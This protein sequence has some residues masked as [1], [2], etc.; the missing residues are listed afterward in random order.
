MR[1][2]KLIGKTQKEI[3]SDADTI[4][5]QLMVRAGMIRQ[6]SAGVYSY[7][8]LAHRALKKV[9]NIIRDEMDKAG[10]QEV[11][12]PVLQPGE[13]WEKSG[14]GQAFGKILFQVKDRKDRELVLGP[15]HE[16]VI[17]D[18]VSFFVKSY[19]DLPVM[20]YQIQTKF[21]DEPRPRGGLIR[22]REF[23]M[24]D[25]Y[26]FDVDE[27]GLD[28]SYQKMRKSYQNIYRR[29]GLPVIMIEADSGAIGGKDSS[30]F[31][32]VTDCGED[33]IVYCEKCGYAANAEKAKSVKAP[34]T[35]EEALAMEDVHTPGQ[36]TIE[37]VA[38]FLGLERKQ[39]IKAVFYYADGEIIF[40]AIRG[41]IEVNEIKLKNILKADE[42]R[43]ALPEEVGKAHLVAG[44][45]SPV[46]LTGIKVVVDESVKNGA[47]FVAGANKPDYHIKNVNFP[48][49]FS[50]DIVA[51]I[52]L[53][54]AGEGCIQCQ[55]PLKTVRGIEVGHIF[56]LGTFLAEKM[57]AYYADAEGNSRPIVMGCYGIGVGRLLASVIEAS[58][59]EKGIIWPFSVAPFEVYL[60]PLFLED[61]R[62][63]QTAEMLYNE[64]TDSGIEVLYDDRME[65]PGVK[66][67]DADL[68]GIPL[69]I[70]VSPRTLEKNSVELKWRTEK[71]ADLVSLDGII[72]QVKKIV[73]PAKHNA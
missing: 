56:K 54:C 64:L 59:D 10:G 8:P 67:N 2:S 7:L 30:E 18:L 53:A 68:L 25:L 14:R 50:A 33:I 36:K 72:D 26:S 73:L 11:T 42:L 24:K 47:N 5:H 35:A 34:G 62:V 16:E 38:N 20:L 51:D 61:E 70:T 13:L 60:C 21:R 3:P 46:G 1:F 45:A 17:T 49:D 66:F 48:R 19:R 15:T 32:A 23:T 12:L 40:V 63:S 65:S 55:K 43:L 27:K 44:S 31:M 6:V 69:R 29:A 22:V 28:V 9:E 58:H 39:T 71:K 41:D 57:G 37:E 4:S 52:S